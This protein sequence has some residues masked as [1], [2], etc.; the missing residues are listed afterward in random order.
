[1]DFNTVEWIA[2]IGVI[3]AIVGIIIASVFAIVQILKR[4]NAG[5]NIEQKSGFLSKGSQGVQI[6]T[7]QPERN[8]QKTDQRSS[9]EGSGK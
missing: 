9:E 7:N 3:V 4:S 2:I 8:E 5:V 1:M 6:T